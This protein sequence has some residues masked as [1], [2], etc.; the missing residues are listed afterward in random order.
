MEHIFHY[1]C[2]GFDVVLN[3]HYAQH[4][5]R[6]ILRGGV[7]RTYWVYSDES[8][9]RQVKGLWSVVS[10]GHAVHEQILLR[11]LLLDALNG[12]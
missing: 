6:H 4:L 12:L 5:P 11:L 1:A 8:K 10:K 9:N 2:C 7:P 3:F